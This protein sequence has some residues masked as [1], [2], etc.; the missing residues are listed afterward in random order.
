[1]PKLNKVQINHLNSSITPKKI[2]AVIKSL[3]TKKIE[4]GLV[5]STG[6]SDLERR[7]NTYI[8]QTIPQN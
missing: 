1:V 8:L 6:L 4:A 3:P 5:Q 7:P 2:A